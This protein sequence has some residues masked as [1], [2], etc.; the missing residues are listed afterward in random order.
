MTNFEKWKD[1]I[2]E[3]GKASDTFPAVVN[4]VPKICT[5]KYCTQTHCENCDLY[6]AEARSCFIRFLEWC[7]KEYKE[8]PKLTKRQRAFLE[9]LQ[10]GWG[11]RDG[12]GTLYFYEG[13]PYRKIGRSGSWSFSGKCVPTSY[14]MFP[15]FPFIKWEDEPYSIEEMLTWEVEDGDE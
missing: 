4:D 12:D 11:A 6:G 10:T 3:M 2:F 9:A 7:C 14:A 1:K 5:Q 8:T 13:K 15:D